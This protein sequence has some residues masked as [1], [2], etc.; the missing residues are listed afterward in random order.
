MANLDSDCTDH[1]DS[2]CLGD[3]ELDDV[4][5]VAAIMH[6][7]AYDLTD[8]RQDIYSLDD[9]QPTDAG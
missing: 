8:A 7:W 5:W 4:A 6:A 9:G 2:N 1:A 3:D